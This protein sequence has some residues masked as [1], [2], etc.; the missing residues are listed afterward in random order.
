MYNLEDM[1]KFLKMFNLPRLNQEEIENRNRTISSNAIESVILKLPANR[2]PG[3]DGFTGEFCQTL[4]RRVS[5]YP[6]QTIPQNWRGR[7]PSELIL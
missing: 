7:N 5:I 2:S 3:P 6:A 1:D 4:K